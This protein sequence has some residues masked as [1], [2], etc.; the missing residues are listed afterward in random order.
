MDTSIP[1]PPYKSLARASLIAG[2]SL[3]LG[4][5][6]DYLFY[7]KFPGLSFSLYVILVI[8]GLFALAAFFKQKINRQAVWLLAPILFFSAMVFIRSSYLL[9]FLNIAASF[10]LLLFVAETAFGKKIRGY[11]SGD[12]LNIVF[13]PFRFL[14]SLFRSLSDLFSRRGGPNSK[15]VLPQV[16]KGAAMAAPAL[17][18]FLLLFSSADLVFK[19]YLFDIVRFDIKPETLLRTILVIFATFALIGAYSYVFTKKEAPAAAQKNGGPRSIGHIESFVLFGLVNA[20]FFVFIIVQLTY[21]FGGESNISLQS[22]TYAEYARR[23]FFELI[24]VAIVSLFLLFLTEKYIV[25]KDTGWHFL[26]FK[27]FGGVLVIQVIIIMTSAFAR[28][29]LYEQAYGFTTLR[30]YSHAF[31][32]FLAVV[33]FLLLYKIIKDKEENKFLFNVFI[34]IIL[35]LAAMNFLNPDA[36]IARK[37]IERLADTGKLDIDY[38]NSLSDDALPESIKALGAPNDD[39][40]KSISRD[41]Y[42]RFQN[43]VDAPDFSKWQSLNISRMNAEKILRPKIQEFEQYKDYQSEG[44]DFDA[45]DD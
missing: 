3:V 4:L 40:R 14:S 38:L 45:S 16:I 37:N 42:W 18:I 2:V 6:F 30:L 33:F 17:F 8:A 22:F 13:L 20:L 10:L 29:S 32:I 25:K 34:S 24:A 43:R 23:G 12:Y 27:I 9:T 26:G 5:F 7:G 39:I 21:L 36:F 11:L 15:R 19:K 41:L 35:F 44:P 31:I 1:D 28:L